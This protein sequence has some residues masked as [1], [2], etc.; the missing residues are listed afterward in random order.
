MAIKRLRLG[1]VKRSAVNDFRKEIKLLCKLRH[2]NIIRLIGA[3][4]RPT[5][6]FIVM[7]Y[8]RLG[9]LFSIVHK[10]HIRLDHAHQVQWAEETARGM[11]Y[12][13]RP[14]ANK[15]PIIHRFGKCAFEG[16]ERFIRLR[17]F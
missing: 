15:P 1:Q 2:P 6:M 3:C 7:E 5:E 9:S 11:E 16:W 13:H 10:P 12:L 17:G 4:T 14:E 8:A